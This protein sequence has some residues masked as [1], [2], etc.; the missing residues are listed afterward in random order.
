MCAGLFTVAV[1]L[2]LVGAKPVFAQSGETDDAVFQIP[3]DDCDT[4]R[5]ATGLPNGNVIFICDATGR[6]CE[7]VEGGRALGFCAERY[8]DGVAPVRSSPLETNVT[9]QSSTHGTIT[10]YEEAGAPADLVC[11]TFVH[12]ATGAR[13]CRKIVPASAP[14]PPLPPCTDATSPDT[15]FF[16]AARDPAACTLLQ[17]LLTD[18]GFSAPPDISFALFLDVDAAGEP[19][20]EALLVCGNRTLQCASPTEALA[21]VAIDYQ[22]V[23]QIINTPLLCKVGGTTYRC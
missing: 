22:F 4:L 18:S 16:R 3:Q 19:G 15:S 6:S 12:Q 21:N 2:S 1:V 23:K 13:A 5:V 7:L 10:G 17:D 11:E 14:L 9:I 8:P 20:S